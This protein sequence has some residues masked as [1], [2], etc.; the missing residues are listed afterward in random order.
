VLP[1]IALELAYDKVGD[2]TQAMQVFSELM[3]PDLPDARRS[4]LRNSLLHYCE[5]DTLAMA[6]V[7]HFLENG[8]IQKPSTRIVE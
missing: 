1:K 6:K 7:A 3:D 2:G 8:V 4:N 5:R